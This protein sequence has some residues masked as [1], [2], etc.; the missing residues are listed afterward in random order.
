MPRQQP[1]QPNM[2]PNAHYTDMRAPTMPRRSLELVNCRALG[3]SCV[4]AALL[5]C[6]SLT[7][8][9]VSLPPPEPGQA[10][11]TMGAGKRPFENV[12]ERRP[13]GMC[14]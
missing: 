10:A 1:A 2:L 14:E 13:V 9:A 4:P 6:P 8:L 5:S 7:R 12:F 11:D 3:A